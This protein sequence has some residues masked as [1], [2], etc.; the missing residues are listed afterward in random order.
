[1]SRFAKVFYIL[2][3]LVL[4]AGAL[5]YFLF[6]HLNKITEVNRKDESIDPNDLLLSANDIRFQSEDGVDL[7]GWL[8]LGKPN[9][10]VVV[11]AHDYRSDR[12]ATLSK[13]EGLIT[14]LN[15]DGYFIFVFNFRGHGLSGSRSALGFRE[16]R[17]LEGAFK[18]VLRYKQIARRVAVVGIGMGAIATAQ[19]PHNVDEVKFLVLDSIYESVPSKFSEEIITELPFISFT[20]PLLIK[21]VGL[22]L[23]QMLRIP[24]TDLQLSGKMN[25]LYP[26]AILFVEKTPPRPEVVALYEAAKEPKELL[27][28]NETATGELIGEDRQEYN[29]QL[30][31]KI[32]QYLPPVSHQKTLEIPK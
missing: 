3:T 27:Q 31:N 20:R 14:S 5:E 19:A 4:I 6:T 25:D 18:A 16:S 11:F 1:M 24:T 10:P 30:F 28:M 7:H 8:I 13:L 32:H 15:K 2:G 22:N 26:K 9:Y 23:K 17:D 12:S 21:A 29:K